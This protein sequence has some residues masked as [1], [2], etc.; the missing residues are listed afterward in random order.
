MPRENVRKPKPDKWAFLEEIDAPQWVDFALERSSHC[1]ERDDSWFDTVHSFH[2][3]SFHDLVSASTLAGQTKCK[4]KKPVHFNTG[5]VN[6]VSKTR[7]SKQLPRNKVAGISID[8]SGMDKPHNCQT[9]IAEDKPMPFKSNGNI[10]RGRSAF[11]QKLSDN[12]ATTSRSQ[13]PI[14]GNGLKNSR[15]EQAK[16]STVYRLKNQS[17]TFSQIPGKENESKDQM[18][19]QVKPSVAAGLSNQS[20]EACSQIPSKGIEMK[21]QIDEQ[22]QSSTVGTLSDQ[23]AEACSQRPTEGNEL[24]DQIDEQVKSL[25]VSGPISQSTETCSHM[26]SMRHELKNQTDVQLNSSEIGDLNNQSMA[27]EIRAPMSRTSGLLSMLKMASLRRSC[28]ML[29]MR[30]EVKDAEEPKDRDSSN[31]VSTGSLGGRSRK[32][33]SI[34][35]INNNSQEV[36][37]EG[38]VKILKNPVQGSTISPIEHNGK[39]S[40]I[41]SSS[42]IVEKSQIGREAAVTQKKTRGALKAV[43]RKQGQPIR[44]VSRDL[45]RS[46]GQLIGGRNCDGVLSTRT[47]NACRKPLQNVHNAVL[48][49]RNVGMLQNQRFAGKEN[50]HL[51]TIQMSK[52]KRVEAKKPLT[53][54]KGTVHRQM[55]QEEII[56]SAQPKIESM[57]HS[58]KDIK[59]WE[60]SS[61]RSYFYLSQMQR[62]K[63]NREIQISK[64]R[65]R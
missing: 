64:S 61:G 56:R 33:S 62:D 46:Q 45:A 43:G 40:S 37:K 52:V 10:N 57:I 49:Q 30:V 5:L 41:G 44:D 29:P 6:S 11:L 21:N 63:A 13:I 26:F 2:Q 60:K 58:I 25:T 51:G 16:S 38:K 50:N 65:Y 47:K 22:V 1:Q 19:D 17:T 9:R 59:Q 54:I 28:G 3:K 24:K 12:T 55:G 14:I 4:V 36:K 34:G 18:D 20:D 31:K 48:S 8:L 15:Y 27:V 7:G 32:I 42:T 39:K 35:S 23:S 53:T